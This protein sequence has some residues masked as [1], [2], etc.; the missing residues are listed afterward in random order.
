MLKKVSFVLVGIGLA[1][2]IAFSGFGIW[3]ATRQVPAFDAAGYI[4]QGETEEVKSISF[5]S[6]EAYTS[7]L[8]GGISFSDTDGKKTTVPRESFVY[9]EDSSV[10]ALSDGVLVDFNDLSDNFINNYYINAGLCLRDSNGSYTAEATA[11]TMTFGEHLWKLSDTKYLIEAP[12]LKVYLSEGDVR[13]VKDYVQVAVTADNIVHLLTPDNLW[14]TISEECYIETDQGVKIYPVSQLID[15][16]TYKLSMAKLSVTPEDAIV[17]SELETRRQIVPELNIE[18]ID[19]ADGQDGTDGQSGQEGASGTA[20]GAGKNGATGTA[21]AGGASGEGGA[22]GGHGASGKDAM[23]VSTTNSALPTMSIT[24]WKVSA[25]G[26]HGTI[27]VTDNGQSLQNVG[28]ITD[29]MTRYPGRVTITEVA[30]GEVV[31]C[32]PTNELDGDTSTAFNFYTG[33]EEVPFFTRGEALKPDTE[34][35]LS[36]TAYYAANNLVYSRE[37]IG[38]VFYTDSTGVHLTYQEATQTSVTLSAA[39]GSDYAGSVRK[40]TVYLMTP[41]QAKTFSAA[42]IS[43]PAMYVAAHDIPLSETTTKKDVVFDKGLAPNQ[44]YV[45]RVYVETDS[46]LKT[47]TQQKLEV[48]TLKRAPVFDKTDKPSVNYNRASGVFEVFRPTVTDPDGGAVSYTYTAYKK[49]EANWENAGERTITPSTGEPVE[50]A[51]AP[52]E[53]YRFEVKMT[54][55]D[56]EKTVSYDLGRSEE[57]KSEGDSMPKIT[58]TPE[59]AGADYNKYNGTLRIALGSNSSITVD[60]THPLTLEL[61]ADQIAPIKVELKGS[62]P[63]TET[64]RYTFTLDNTTNTNQVDVKVNLENLYKNTNYSITV[65]GYLNVGDGNDVVNR[66][67]G[68]VSFRTY[69]TVTLNTTWSKPTE[70]TGAAISRTLA[71]AVQD[72]QAVADPVRKTYAT[73]QL[74]EGQVIVELFSGTGTGKLRI[75]QKNYNTREDLEE[76]FG[77]GLTITE[78][79]FGNPPL[80]KDGNYTLTVSEVADK[81]YTLSLGYVNTFDD[82]MNAAE[83]VSAEPTPP[84]LLVDPS[85]GVKATPI[86]N[87]DIATY[88]GTKDESL[89]DDAIMGYTLEASYDNVQRIGKSITYYA[90]EYNTFFNALAKNDPIKVEDAPLMKMTL[91]IDSGSNFVP[92]VAVLFGGGTKSTEPKYYN[93]YNTYYAGDPSVPGSSLVSGMGRGFRYIFAYTVEYAGSS[94]GEGTATLTYPYGHKDYNDYNLVHGGVKENGVQIG[95][96]VAYVLNSG[97][98]EA[99]QILPDFH[100]YVSSTTQDTL[101][102]GEATTATGKVEL[103]YKWRDPDGLIIDDNTANNTKITYTYSNNPVS[104]NVQH[105]S[106]GDKW[107][108]VTM[109]YAVVKGTASCLMPEVNVCAYRLDYDQMLSR[110]NMAKDEKAMA[111]GVIPLEWSWEQQF[112]QENYRNI[113]LS[114]DMEHLAEN[115]IAF[116][117]DV[118]GTSS[119]P[120]NALLSRAISLKLTLCTTGG[121]TEKTFYLPLVSDVYGT[122]AKLATGLLGTEFLGEEFKVTEAVLLYDTGIQGWSLL[123][124]SNNR[125]GF[126]LQY[127]E[128]GGKQ[129]EFTNYIGASSL[130]NVPANGALLT[131]GQNFSEQQ[132]RQTIG[133]T[134]K[135]DTKMALGTSNVIV[136][137]SGSTR[138]L[139]PDRYG[140]DA[141]NSTLVSQLSGRYLTPKKVAA[142]QLSFPSNGDQGTLSQMT[143]TIDNPHFAVSSTEIKI[144]NI[145]VYGLKNGGTIYA[146]A[147]ES[148]DEAEKLGAPQKAFVKIA[149]GSDGKP[150]ADPALTSLVSQKKYYVAFYHVADNGERHLLLTADTA[151]VAVYEVTTSRDA[152]IKVLE[153]EYRNNS[154]FD[155]SMVFTYSIDRLFNINISYDIYANKGDAINGKN[156]V[157]THKQM[158]TGDENA[159]LNAPT[160][161]SWENQISINLRPSANRAKLEPGKTY[162]LKISAT[163]GDGTPAGNAIEEFKL[164]AIGNYDALIYVSNA[165]ADSIT[166]W[167][168][169]NDPQYTLMGRDTGAGKYE[170]AL[171]AVRFTDEYGNLRR[172]TY[173]DKVYSAN[174]LRKEFVLSK[175]VL[176]KDNITANQQIEENKTYQIHIYA[177]PDADHNGTIQLTGEEQLRDWTKFF[178]RNGDMGD[179]GTELQKIIAGFWDNNTSHK[180]NPVEAQLKIASKSQKTT[181]EEGWIL[182]EDG[183]YPSRFDPTTVRIQFEESVGLLGTGESAEPVFKQIDWSVTGKAGDGSPVSASGTAR[184]SKRNTLLQSG[185]SGGYYDMYYYDIP[186]ELGQGNY[187]IV[188]QFRTTEEATSPT[189]SITIRSGV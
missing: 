43:T 145:R 47:L 20:G 129:F 48:M 172:T 160:T 80:N 61:Y 99:P 116:R 185:K 134:V 87:S 95:N 130:S 117:F 136:A 155:K 39:V 26:L 73:E 50:F 107:Y 143:P 72:R 32:Y 68:T 137:S 23:A 149:I 81:S 38:R 120:T 94:T 128:D 176:K 30:T 35:K 96:K 163:E 125:A 1:A 173:D 169:I 97:M 34:Y 93:G 102:Q 6:G 88:G 177:V 29:C 67:I 175:G 139:Y 64:D 168:T 4:L 148:R 44:T 108:S 135:D 54:F 77:S 84:D 89:P 2:I 58:L 24:E 25:T 27:K 142:Y 118:S 133:N 79:D 167:V 122:Y 171:Y 15:S 110:F 63:V 162:Y 153:Q 144:E 17:L 41:E 55:N 11:G 14:M 36:V 123:E 164:T 10:M 186:Y 40:A 83:V 9:F 51:M 21:G 141:H 127:V 170:G 154:Y 146:A 65:S 111:I 159:I 82:I 126:A 71:L 188:L 106:V 132:L 182:N 57:M 103:H 86:Y 8:S 33:T 74:Q 91:P 28:D 179:C 105:T 46:G 16:G 19:G 45:A 62:E 42:S 178:N 76:I 90:F 166:F 56:S 131:T 113:Q 115:F 78:A 37:F 174:D 100:T 109:N 7:T 12:S 140:V 121:T 112:G 119:A 98:C 31:Y 181:T 66:T 53:V 101:A 156:P 13:E 158:A 92:K 183:V 184:Y 138:Y 60:P 75:A 70:T 59:S 49:N 150:T 152:V 18:A 151:Q 165:K 85:D 189:K 180:E 69:E 124:D 22:N 104:Q 3:R 161:L 5:R 114:M 187:V 157:L 52:G 147:Y